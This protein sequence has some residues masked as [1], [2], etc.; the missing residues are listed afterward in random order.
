MHTPERIHREHEEQFMNGAFEKRQ[1]ILSDTGILILF[2]VFLVLLHTLVNNQYGFHRDELLTFTNARHLDWGYVVY[3]PLTPFL[4]RVQLQFF[5]TSLRSFRFFAAVSQGIA[6]LFTGLAA[7]ELGGKREAQ[8]VA[9]LAVA[10]CGNSLV[11]GSFFSYTSFDYMCWVL[12]AYFVVRL[13]TS[14]DPR[15]WIAIGASIGLGMMAKYSMAFLVLGVV[16]G[17]LLTPTR[18]YA[19]S[20]WLWCGVAVALLIMMPNIVWQIGHHFISLEYLK[21]IHARDIARGWTGHFLLNQLW[22]SANPVS[23]PLW[24]AGLWFLFATAEGRRY[25]MLGWMYAIPLLAFLVARGRDYY[26]APAYP[27]LIAAGAVWGEQWVGSLT[28][29]SALIVR[30]IT[31]QSLAIAGLCTAALTLPIAPL[32]SRWWSIANDT[33]GVFDSQ[34]GW[35]DMVE[36][37]AK[38]RDSLPVE[39]RSRFAILAGDEGEA[40]AVNLYGPAYGLPAA[41]SGMNSN[42]LRGYGNPPPLTVIVLGQHRD[43]VDRN[44]ESCTLAGRLTNRYGIANSSVAGWDDIF[45]CR[46]LRQSWPEFWAHFQ[47]YG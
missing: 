32:N 26:L 10:I 31:W 35:P 27:M 2:S 46:H 34:I 9:A 45:V 39:D 33:N 37:V 38:V 40:G 5:G 3:P 6:V 30:R 23:V 44:F 29:R 12:V 21:S 41:I 20:P 22:K 42:W 8:I 43:F 16:G 19:K 18:R 36:A 17:L 11:H 14:G 47:Y 4:A 25:R 1:G 7:R 13:L 24:C 28:P 15:W